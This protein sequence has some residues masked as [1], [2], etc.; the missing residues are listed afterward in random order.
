MGLTCLFGTI[1]SA[2]AAK[3]HPPRTET[4]IDSPHRIVLP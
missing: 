2:E 4:A 3:T 1:P